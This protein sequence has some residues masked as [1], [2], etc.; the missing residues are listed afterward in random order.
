MF[1]CVP[2]EMLGCCFFLPDLVKKK[3]CVY[4]FSVPTIVLI[5]T[6]NKYFCKTPA[7]TV[8]FFL[9]FSSPLSVLIAAARCSAVPFLISVQSHLSY[10][11]MFALVEED[12]EFAHTFC[13]FIMFM[14]ARQSARL[15]VRLFICVWVTIIIIT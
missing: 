12:G 13:L 2:K 11:S 7:F 10:V 4:L 14:S 8:F 5:F 15:S 1:L 6:H 3:K 9:L